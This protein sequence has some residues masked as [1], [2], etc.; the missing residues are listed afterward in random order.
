MKI[1]HHN[2]NDGKAA[3]AVVCDYFTTIYNIPISLE[4]FISVNYNNSIP[5]ADQVEENDIVFIVDYSFTESTVNNLYEIS[6]K[7]NGNVYW[8]D[9]HKSSLEVY[10]K[11]VEDGICKEVII[12]MDKSGARIVY[13]RY[14]NYGLSIDN[15][16][17]E[18]VDDYDRWIHKFPE[19]MWFNI[20]STMEYTH[21]TDSIWYNNPSKIIENGKLIEEYD[22]TKNT[23]LV[24]NNAYDITINNHRCIVLNSPERSSKAFSKYFDDYKF[25]IVWSFNGENFTYSIYSGLEDIDCSEIAK[26]FNPKGGGHKGAAGFVS[27][28]IIFTKGS[29]FV[30]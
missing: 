6:T 5:T 17:I 4:D 13:D 23:K 14:K 16:V 9:H 15:T 3:A 29:E 30:I 25:A 21:P 19:S 2:D 22:N 1:F 24:K 8:Y 10:N 28:K 12:D 26:H 11:V 18:L 7:T 27:D 20:G